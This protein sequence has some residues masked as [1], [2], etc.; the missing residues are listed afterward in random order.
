MRSGG[1]F[2]HAPASWKEVSRFVAKYAYDTLT[3]LVSYGS[4]CSKSPAA[5]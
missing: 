4:F 2:K 5:L 3:N 1:G